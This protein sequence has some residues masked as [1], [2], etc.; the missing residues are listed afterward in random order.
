MRSTI[1]SSG[2]SFLLMFV[3]VNVA[4]AGWNI[5][6]PTDGQKFERSVQMVSVYIQ[7]AQTPTG[8][9]A[10]VKV[11]GPSGSN[12]ISGQLPQAAGIYLGATALAPDG[13]FTV[14]TYT[15]KLL[16]VD[17]NLNETNKKT[18]TFKIENGTYSEPSDP[19]IENPYQNQE[20]GKTVNKIYLSG[21][22]GDMPNQ[23]IPDIERKV[24]GPD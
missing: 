14:G 6:S 7:K 12:V 2:F 24:T 22:Y 20:F 11:F 1:A 21:K 16:Y 17:A 13:G 15:V 23:V 8:Q 18:T 3:T 5:L 19:T 10:W 9:T 4:N